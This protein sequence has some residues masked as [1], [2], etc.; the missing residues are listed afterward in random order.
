MESLTFNK[1][2]WHYRVARWGG[3]GESTVATDVCSYTRK[4][5][6]GSLLALLIG[7]LCCLVTT[8]VI[9]FVTH[10]FVKS[11]PQALVWISTIVC[12]VYLA[13]ITGLALFFVIRK[14]IDVFK[15]A[16]RQAKYKAIANGTYVA[17][18]PKPEKPPKPIKEPG[19]LYEMYKAWKRKYCV[20][21]QIK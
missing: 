8:P 12:S 1:D 9:V 5:I 4:F 18:A 7:A 6:L 14:C 11:Y 19:M 3:L 20:K 21:I 17:P 10:F 16:A 13:A 15:E 2:V